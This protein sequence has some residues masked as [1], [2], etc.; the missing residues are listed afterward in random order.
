MTRPYFPVHFHVKRS[1]CKFIL[2]EV[3]K[4]FN[5]QGNCKLCHISSDVFE[6]TDPPGNV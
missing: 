2:T 5:K 4:T 6:V 1:C 3:R